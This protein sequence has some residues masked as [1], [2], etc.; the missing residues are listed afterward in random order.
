M[1]Y[2]LAVAC[3]PLALLLCGRPIA[4][5][6]AAILCLYGLVTFG[7]TYAVSVVVAWSL[8]AHRAHDRRTAAIVDELRRLRK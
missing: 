6:G 5:F 7:I 8:V 2:F 3:P 4:A 1:L